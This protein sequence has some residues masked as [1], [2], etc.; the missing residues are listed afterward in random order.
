ML[1]S[2]NNFLSKEEIESFLNKETK[3]DLIAN[4]VSAKISSMLPNQVY[5]RWVE[6]LTMKPGSWNDEHT[7]VDD[8]NENLVSAILY[9]NQGFEGGQ[10]IFQNTLIDPNP[11]QLVFFLSNKNSPHSVTKVVGCDRLSISMFFDYNKEGAACKYLSKT[12]SN[13]YK[14]DNRPI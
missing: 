4:K 11:G 9:L 12:I 10:F 8:Y 14:R 3:I 2:I 1:V 7:D 6:F 5:P 13:K